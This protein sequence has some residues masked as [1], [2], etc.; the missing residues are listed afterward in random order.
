MGSGRP[1]GPVK[2]GVPQWVG[3]GGGGGEGGAG[4]VLLCWV[5]GGGSHPG[6]MDAGCEHS[7]FPALAAPGTGSPGAALG[8]WGGGEGES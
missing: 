7:G 6:G 2:F 5:G 3:V 4:C 8:E 1:A